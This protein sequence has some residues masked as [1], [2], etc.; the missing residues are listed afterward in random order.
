MTSALQGSW[1]VDGLKGS[2]GRNWP[3][4]LGPAGLGG[5][6]LLIL[7]EFPGPSLFH[8]VVLHGCPMG[9]VPHEAQRPLILPQPGEAPCPS[10]R[11]SPRRAAAQPAR[12]HRRWQ[13]PWHALGC[14]SAPPL[15]S[16][17]TRSLTRL[18]SW[19]AAQNAAWNAST[20]SSAG[21]EATAMARVGA[22]GRLPSSP[23]PATD[24][25]RHEGR[26]TAKLLMPPRRLA[27]RRNA[28]ERANLLTGLAARR[29][30]GAVLDGAARGVPQPFL[31]IFP[32]PKLGE[33][34]GTTRLGVATAPGSRWQDA[35]RRRPW[36]DGGAT[37]SAMSGSKARA[38]AG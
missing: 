1:A 6:S 19:P 12:R 23:A 5:G 9:R 29:A 35:T 20:Q 3:T 18:E 13:R 10:L 36:G 31:Q 27:S 24:Y 38:Q 17:L 11:R 15:P 22:A 37:R 28:A 7:P 26:V 8:V 33:S 25:P 32:E 34:T 16:G 14:A 4:G 21:G 2:L 30:F